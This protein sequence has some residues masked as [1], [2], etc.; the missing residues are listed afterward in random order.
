M[1][2]QQ[3]AANGMMPMMMDPRMM[4]QQQQHMMQNG[5]QPQMMMHDS[6]FMYQQQQQQSP[7][8]PTPSLSSGSYNRSR[9]Y[10][11]D[12]QSV[13]GASVASG[14]SNHN[15]RPNY[16]RQHVSS[17]ASVT[18]ASKPTNPSSV[19]PPAARRPRNY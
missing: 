15:K 12:N 5:I 19:P 6:R 9:Y 10:S 14:D 7:L 16:K 18:S 1:M 17:S 11:G 3:Y 2:Q 4:Q 13:S 8:I